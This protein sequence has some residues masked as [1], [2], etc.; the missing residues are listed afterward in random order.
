MKNAVKEYTSQNVGEMYFEFNEQDLIWVD[1]L[2]KNWLTRKVPTELRDE[3]YLHH[4]TYP[5]AMYSPIE[6]LYAIKDVLQQVSLLALNLRLL[7]T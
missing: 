1:A 7:S 6:L 2:H 3:W 5:R 4:R